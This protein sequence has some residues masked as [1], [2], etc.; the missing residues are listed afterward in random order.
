MPSVETSAPGPAN[1]QESRTCRKCTETK[2]VTADTWPYRSS[3]KGQPYQAYGQVCLACEKKRKQE[4][5]ARRDKIAAMVKAPAAPET[6]KA[7]AKRKPNR[8]DVD[9]A[10]K[11]GSRVLNEYAPSVL[12]RVLEY[13]DDPYHEH[14]LWAIELLA[15]RILPRKLYEELGGQAAGVGSLQ[16]KRPQFQINILP[17]SPAPEG[18]VIPG[19]AEVE[20]VELLPSPQEERSE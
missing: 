10:L 15:Q 3:R 5:E 16:D 7:G 12:A 9:Q 8:L 2:V 1:P 11:A 18:R 4:Y 20:T 19:Q 14:H 17:A 6:D 13:A